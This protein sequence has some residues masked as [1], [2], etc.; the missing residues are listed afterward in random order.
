MTIE[1]VMNVRGVVYEEDN[2]SDHVSADSNEYT[3]STNEC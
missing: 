3:F 1:L 2:Q